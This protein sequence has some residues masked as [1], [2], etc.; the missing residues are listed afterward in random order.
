MMLIKI[1]F[2]CCW[3][4]HVP[5]CLKLRT[6]ESRRIIEAVA[7][8]IKYFVAAS[9]DRGFFLL[10]SKGIIARRLISR[11]THISIKLVLAIVIIGPIIIVK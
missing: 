11:P 5:V 6:M 1:L 2:V 9:V 8:V 10:I 7:C 3:N 4:I